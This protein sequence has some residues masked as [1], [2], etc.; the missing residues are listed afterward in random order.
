MRRDD[1]G[2]IMRQLESSRLIKG[3]VQGAKKLALRSQFG[4][5]MRTRFEMRL[6]SLQ[7]RAIQLAVQISSDLFERAFLIFNGLRLHRV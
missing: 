3:K 4:G 1:S 2:K 6:E 7:R 5:A